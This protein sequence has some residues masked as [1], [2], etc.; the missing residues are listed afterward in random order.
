LVL[1]PLLPQAPPVAE[2]APGLRYQPVLPVLADSPAGCLILVSRSRYS[3][4][5]LIPGCAAKAIK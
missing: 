3:A 2:L 4:T 1:E 5:L